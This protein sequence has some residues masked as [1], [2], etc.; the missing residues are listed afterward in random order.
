MRQTL[1]LLA[2]LALTAAACA[3]SSPVAPLDVR[4]NTV[5]FP[6]DGGGDPSC[7]EDPGTATIL[8][9][10]D[11]VPSGSSVDLTADFDGVPSDAVINWGDGSEPTVGTIAD[12][13]VVTGS[14]VYAT[15]GVYTVS[16]TATGCNGVAVLVSATNFVVVYNADG[17]FVTGG[18]WIDS[19]AG[20]YAADPAAGGKATFGFVAKLKKGDVVPTGNT[21]FQLHSTK[22]NFK[23]KSYDWMAASPTTITFRGRG[24]VNGEAGY[25]FLVT[26]VDGRAVGGPDAFRIRIWDEASGAVAYD[27]QV[28]GDTA[29]NAAPTTELA[30]GSIVIH[31]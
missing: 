27:S 16:I 22:M 13:G 25:R 15:A 11:P 18:G 12:G 31:K 20:A 26:A 29:D 30:H 2:V 3:D 7:T 8:V 19:P 28:T 9:A 17:G 5:V 1:P 4:P 24:T 14:H 6:G 21:E 23:S 10:A